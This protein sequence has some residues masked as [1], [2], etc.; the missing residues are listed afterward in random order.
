M[1]QKTRI[2]NSKSTIRPILQDA[3]L[4]CTQGRMDILRILIQSELPL[5]H[6]DIYG[7]LIQTGINRVTVYRVLESLLNVGIVHRVEVGDRIWRFAVCGRLHSGHC[8]PHFICREC[9]RIECLSECP[10]PAISASIPRHRI[11]EQ[12]VYLR[13]LCEACAEG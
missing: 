12:E 3:G 5:T 4:R 2:Q 1:V 11:E 6:E 8:H 9:G 10:M 7:R 13:G